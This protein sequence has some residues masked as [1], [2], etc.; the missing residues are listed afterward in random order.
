MAQSDRYPSMIL[1]LSGRIES[2]EEV[3]Y[4]PLE[5]AGIAA[6]EPEPESA[7]LMKGWICADAQDADRQIIDQHG[8][9]WSVFD[10]RGVI[11]VSHPYDALRVIG[12]P[13]KRELREMPNGGLGNWLEARL[14][15]DKPLARVVRDDHR[16]LY[17]ATGGKRGYGFSV[18]GGIF[19]I[20]GNRITRY[21]VR[22]VAADPMPVNPLTYAM[23]MAAA[24]GGV[25]GGDL[26]TLAKALT[27]A[28]DPEAM[29]RIALI[30]DIPLRHL[31]AARWLS[32][33][34]N[35]TAFDHALKELSRHRS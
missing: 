4:T 20:K 2:I 9:D 13:I 34:G 3:E 21:Q 33:T 35:T 16:S 26:P 8:G 12:V 29:K 25:A 10:S 30:E 24:F 23:P 27:M 22:T 15:P 18:E 6:G 17:K 11:H 7:W 31:A 19:G 1:P 28:A 32:R 5:K 14:L